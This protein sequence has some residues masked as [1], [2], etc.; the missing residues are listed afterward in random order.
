M[1]F[2]SYFA[3]DTVRLVGG[4]DPWEGLLQT[5][6]GDKSFTGDWYFV[7]KEDR[8]NKADMNV[9]CHQ[10]GFGYALSSPKRH[11]FR[12]PTNVLASN[13]LALL[14]DCTGLEKH[15]SDCKKD[16]FPG[17][18]PCAAMQENV[19]IRCSNNLTRPQGG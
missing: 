7:C 10:L 17:E 3:E 14:L 5:Y 2:I 9:I 6:V 12:N 8:M 1:S 13:R 16:P 18:A 15:I 19:A 11:S 4:S